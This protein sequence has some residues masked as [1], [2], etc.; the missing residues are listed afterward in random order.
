MIWASALGD[1]TAALD[2]ACTAANAGGGFTAPAN[3]VAIP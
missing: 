3:P 1:F 2:L